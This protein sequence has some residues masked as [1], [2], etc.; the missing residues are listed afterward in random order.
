MKRIFLLLDYYFEKLFERLENNTKIESKYFPYIRIFSSLFTLLYFLPKFS[1]IGFLPNTFFRPDYF[2]FTNLFNGFLPNWYFILTDIIIVIFLILITIGVYSRV[3]LRLLALLLI[4]NYGFQFSLGKIDH[5]LLFPLFFLYLSFTNSGSSLAFKKDKK[6]GLDSIVT[7][8]MAIFIV[9]AYFTA[10]LEKSFVWVDFD[11]STSGVLSWL[12][13]GYFLVGRDQLLANNFLD[14]HPLVY[15]IMDYSGVFL[16][17]L[18]FAFLFYS[19]KTW[20]LYLLFI[21]IFH[22]LNTLILNIPFTPHII[23]VS[24]WLHYPI[25]SE[26]KYLYLLFL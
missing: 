4:F 6:I 25:L 17:L 14:L 19:K 1:W 13:S 24:A 2:N 12:Y 5:L 18:G 22:L 9:F 10:G 3:C 8:I 11:L 7:S 15:E 26:K 21:V 16:E 20:N 23:L